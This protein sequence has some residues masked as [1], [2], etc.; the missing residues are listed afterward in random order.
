MYILCTVQHLGKKNTP[1]H[2]KWVQMSIPHKSRHV[3]LTCHSCCCA[4]CFRDTLNDGMEIMTS[5]G[6]A[7]LLPAASLHLC[8]RL[9]ISLWI[10]MFPSF[11]K[12]TTFQEVD[13]NG[14]GL[15]HSFLRFDIFQPRVLRVSPI[16]LKAPI[17]HPWPHDQFCG[18]QPNTV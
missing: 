14:A 1:R 3:V 9:L 5:N 13:Q 17:F 11:S 6:W 10:L 18:S 4:L 15:S 16:L 12:T 8:Q 2:C 7:P